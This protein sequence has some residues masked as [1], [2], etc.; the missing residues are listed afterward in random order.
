MYIKITL[1]LPSTN[2]EQMNDILFDLGC[3]GLEVVDW[4]T[5]IRDIKDQ[6]GEIYTLSRNDYPKEAAIIQAYFENEDVNALASKINS[7]NAFFHQ[8]NVE[9]LPEEDYDVKW[10]QQHHEVRIT[11][12]IAI[13]PPWEHSDAQIQVKINP[14]LGF[15]TGSHPTT[16]MCLYYLSKYIDKNADVLD[17]GTGSGVI[18]I[19]GRMLTR[20]NVV[21]VDVDPLALKN[22]QE[23]ASLNACQIEFQQ[24][25]NTVQQSFDVIVANLVTPILATLL[26]EMLLRLKTQGIMI[27]SGILT[28]E[29]ERIKTSFSLFK[30]DIL[31]EAQE[32]DFV[33][34][35][36]Q[37]KV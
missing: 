8:C 36:L 24:D 17:V 20:G 12:E 4:D 23:N 5:M 26:P 19:L 6:Y 34:Y 29:R 32:G 15:G 18:A 16:R 22:A 37:K 27:V 9:V 13:I 2:V 7:L 30:L 10:Q 28:N 33:A 14:G 3:I 31:E 1:T 25:I 11:N 21:A 35:I